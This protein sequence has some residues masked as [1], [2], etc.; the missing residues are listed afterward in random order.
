M[1]AAPS[2]PGTWGAAPLLIALLVALAPGGDGAAQE[3]TAPPGADSVASTPG[4][5]PLQQAAST[6]EPS[7]STMGALGTP[8]D[9]IPAGPSDAAE[10]EAWLDGFMTAQ[11]EDLPSAGAT[12]SIVRD[13]RILVAKGYGYSD[14]ESRHEVS[15]SETLFRIGSVSKL[16]VWTAVMQLVEEGRLDLQADVNDY[17]DELRIPEAWGEPIT[18]AHLMSHSPGFEDHVIGLFG[19]DSTSVRPLG[20]ILADELPARVR[21]PGDVASYSNHG[22]G[23]AAYIVERV[24]GLPF[25]QYMQRRI[26]APLGMSGTTLAQPVPAPLGDRLSKGYRRAGRAFHEEGFEYVPLAPVG[27]VSS[28]A[29]DM[30]TLLITY[31]QDGRYGDARILEPST[32]RLMREP[33]LRHAEA[34]NPAL[35]GFMDMSRQ[36]ERVIGHGGD[37]F[38][39]HTLFAIL[40]ERGVGLFVSYNTDT[41]TPGRDRL[42]E[43]FI[44]RYY[45]GE[46]PGPPEPSPDFQSRA[47]RFTGYYRSNRYSHSDFTKVA[48]AVSTL[49]V[50]E[51]DGA[52]VTD[53]TGPT[54]FVEVG[55]VTFR[56]EHG[57]RVMAF[58]ADETG[59]ITEMFLDPYQVVAFERVPLA[60]DP[61]LHT[62]L[63]LGSISLFLL[64]A[65]F[66]PVA[67]LVRRHYGVTLP[68]E[69]RLPFVPRLVAWSATAAFLGFAGVFA[70]GAGDPNEVAMGD[71]TMI[72]LAFMIGYGALGL[73]GL[74]IL[75]GLW[76][77]LSGRGRGFP[78]LVYA[79]LCLAFLATA[80]Q[81]SYWNLLGFQN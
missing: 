3:P 57:D 80:W 38:W 18:L 19:K 20:E 37:T 39:F 42:L 65:I 60:G 41:G 24:S 70:A 35:H 27:A 64:V 55:P 50:R 2:R 45:A 32:A 12:V 79:L 67:G 73:G 62:G 51:S 66:W 71:V 23:L 61:R 9:S 81:M 77:M 46:E 56:E 5:A 43:A 14:V 78:R 10:V 31:L 11:I 28:T 53:A 16:F 63:A 1:S 15:A 17:L 36:G 7:D 25:D 40:P 4:A 72:E 34:V 21:P 75:M 47:R 69:K 26:L 58:R 8:A 59:R 6:L 48:A 29:V 76:V 68:D 54:R 74:S 49:R 52:L 33:L 44:H 22:T 13:G 30:A